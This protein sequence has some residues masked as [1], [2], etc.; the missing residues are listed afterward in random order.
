MFAKKMHID[1]VD[2]PSNMVQI[3]G[4]STESASLPTIA[5]AGTGRGWYNNTNLTVGDNEFDIH[6]SGLSYYMY[7]ATLT[8]DHFSFNSI[9]FE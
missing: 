4:V 2:T 9:W 5:T 6:V 8:S 7:I 3:G 1:V